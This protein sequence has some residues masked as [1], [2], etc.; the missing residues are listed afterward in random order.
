[1]KFYFI[2][3]LL[4]YIQSS[5]L[6]SLFSNGL[7][8]PDLVLCA[9]FLELLKSGDRWGIKGAFSGSVLDILQDSAGLYVSRQV[10]FGI[11]YEII[12]EKMQFPSKVSKA[13]AYVLIAISVK[14]FMILLFSFKHSWGL[15]LKL[16]ILSLFLETLC[17]YRFCR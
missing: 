2:V 12:D 8:A 14:L 4:S 15:N 5:I 11:I 9:Y 10:L 6:A 17:V 3:V 7:L 1:M 13:V 16:L